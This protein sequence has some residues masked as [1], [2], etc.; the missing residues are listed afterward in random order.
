MDPLDRHKARVQELQDA[1]E[2]LMSLHLQVYDLQGEIVATSKSEAPDRHD[3]L[4]TLRKK[5]LALRPEIERTKQQ[6]TKP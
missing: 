3:R 2:R 4:D 5:V 1:V 6:L